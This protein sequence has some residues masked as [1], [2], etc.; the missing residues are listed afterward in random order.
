MKYFVKIWW[1]DG[2]TTADTKLMSEEELIYWFDISDCY[3]PFDYE[4]Y[5]VDTRV[6]EAPFK[7]TYVGWQPKGLI[8][9]VDE[10][11][12]I[13]VSGYGTDH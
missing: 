6:K 1:E 5:A 3:P 12:I 11:G 2:E 8:E 13:V 10:R 9:F 4:I 7:I